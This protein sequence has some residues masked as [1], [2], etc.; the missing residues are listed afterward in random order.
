MF[1]TMLLELFLP[2]RTLKG[3][4]ISDGLRFLASWSYLH[5][6]NKTKWRVTPKRKTYAPAT[7]LLKQTADCTA[8]QSQIDWIST[9]KS[10]IVQE[11]GLLP[12]DARQQ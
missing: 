8:L 1:R 6:K 9:Q 2:F 11:Y 10:Q 3:Q 7:H 4:Q 5:T 12:A